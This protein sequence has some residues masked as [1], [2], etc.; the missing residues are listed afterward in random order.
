MSKKNSLTIDIGSRDASLGGFA[1][2][3]LLLGK[4]KKT[5][6]DMYQTQSG[7]LELS[8]VQTKPLTKALFSLF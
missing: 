8:W 3:L 6:Q 5:L 1:K 2:S 4:T 7:C